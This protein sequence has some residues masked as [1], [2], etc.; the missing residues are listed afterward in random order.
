M[1]RVAIVNG[2][3]CTPDRIVSDCSVILNGSKIDEL[4]VG[5]IPRGCDVIDATGCIV[6]PGFVDIHV[7]GGG[8]GDY[9][10]GTLDSLLKGVNH[11]ARHGTTSL[12]ATTSTAPMEKIYRAFDTISEAMEERVG[13]AEILGIHMEGPYFAKPE[14][15]CHNVELIHDPVPDEIARIIAYSDRLV[16]LTVAPEI[17]GALELISTLADLGVV[18]SGGHAE[19]TFEETMRGVDAGMTHLTHHWSAMQGVHREQAKRIT[20]MVEAG[21]LRDELTTEVIADGKHL[22]TSLLQLAYKCKGR[23]GMCLISD[24]MRA[25]GMPEGRYEVC[26]MDAIVEG[27]VAYTLDKKAFAS[28]IISMDMAVRHMVKVVGVSLLDTIYMATYS[29][30]KIIGVDDRK[31]SLAA[32]KDADVVLLDQ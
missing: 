25:G 30:A 31:G 21:L 20:G 4:R 26:E 7:H 18:V 17:P 23:D 2:V 1:K 5:G 27:G 6:C 8:G 24:S 29:P 12:L 32:G 22:P 9:I 11:H 13:G 15:G 3:V 16:R 28:S 10:D 14:P 19:A